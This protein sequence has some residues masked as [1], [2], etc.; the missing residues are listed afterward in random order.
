ME[1]S[2]REYIKCGVSSLPAICLF[3][4]RKEV[5]VILQCLL[6]P[7]KKYRKT[8]EE[9]S[10]WME[11]ESVSPKQNSCTRSFKSNQTPKG[12]RQSGVDACSAKVNTLK[13]TMESG[14]EL[15]TKHKVFTGWFQGIQ[16][17]KFLCEV[18]NEPYEGPGKWR[19][20]SKTKKKK[21]CIEY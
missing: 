8:A 7:Q 19:K 15:R 18:V 12:R 21:R 10:F 6:Q 9:L 11:S 5:K 2:R 13:N 1:G 16:K 3:C 20:W 4:G 17:N 14:I